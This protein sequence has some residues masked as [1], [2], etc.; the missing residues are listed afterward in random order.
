MMLNSKDNN[1]KLIVLDSIAAILRTEYEKHETVERARVMFLISKKLRDFA[2]TY[3]IPVVVVNQVTDKFDT[4]GKD[5]FPKIG[6]K[7]QVPSLGLSWSKCINTR[8][9]IERTS[10]S[11]DVPDSN[12]NSPEHQPDA[13]EQP[14]KK[15]KHSA[16]QS[17]LRKIHVIFSSTIPMR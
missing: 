15:P 2:D 4:T 5:H 12:N 1:I 3:N 11:I 10:K 8:I 17:I 6:T 14:K 13:S 7:N 9:L 16:E